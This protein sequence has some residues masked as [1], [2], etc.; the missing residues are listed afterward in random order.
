[1]CLVHHVSPDRIEAPEFLAA[2]GTVETEVSN[3]DFLAEVGYKAGDIGEMFLIRNEKAMI[4][5]HVKN[6]VGNRICSFGAEEAVSRL[7][8][9]PG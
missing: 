7:D 8:R 1:M 3:D 5:S 6:S 9:A 4:T 2:M